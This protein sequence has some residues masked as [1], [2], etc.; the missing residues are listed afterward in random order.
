M[1]TAELQ[2]CKYDMR[3]IVGERGHLK[4]TQHR[5]N[6]GLKCSAWN[7]EQNLRF[8]LV[9]GQYS[10]I[11]LCSTEKYQSSKLALGT[12]AHFHLSLGYRFT[13]IDQII[14]NDV[15][16]NSYLQKC[17]RLL[18]YLAYSCSP[19]SI[20]NNR[21]KIAVSQV[22]LVNC[23][24]VM[25]TFTI[26]KHCMYIIFNLAAHLLQS[27]RYVSAKFFHNNER[28]QTHW[29]ITGRLLFTLSKV[30]KTACSLIFR[31]KQAHKLSKIT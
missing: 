2:W 24:G 14:K 15:F 22:R 29:F 5:Q 28:E 10:I 8:I 6:K 19:L 23:S 25:S 11:S 27:C 20:P 17:T 4:I 12:L 31:N 3:T 7:Y 30:L 21:N 1:Y 9:Y 18:S 16:P 26:H 13:Q